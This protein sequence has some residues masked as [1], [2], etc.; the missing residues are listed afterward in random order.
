MDAAKLTANDVLLFKAGDP[1]AFDKIF[2]TL[3]LNVVYLARQLLKDEEDA[4]DIAQETFAK[5]WNLKE[6]FNTYQHIEAF[7]RT[8]ARNACLNVL[9]DKGRAI[10]EMRKVADSVEVAVDQE[11]FEVVEREMFMANLEAKTL[12]VLNEV[13]AELP[14]DKS[15]VLKLFLLDKLTKKQIAD[16]YGI[17]QTAAARKIARAM[18]QLRLKLMQ[19]GIVFIFIVIVNFLKKVFN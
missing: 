8:T 16:R 18:A 12:D 9:R 15:E 4:K 6:R 14:E 10:K 7:M 2:Q 1:N 3:Y 19:R 11:D 5:L 17:S 13:I